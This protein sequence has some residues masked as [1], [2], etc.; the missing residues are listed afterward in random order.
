MHTIV[1]KDFKDNKHYI[2]DNTY[3]EQVSRVNG[4]RYT[5][6]KIVNS[7]NN[8]EAM[9]NIDKRWFVDIY[10]NNKFER[11]I[12]QN[13]YEKFE[14]DVLV[15][16][17]DTLQVDYDNLKHEVV[18][19][20]YNGS[21]TMEEWF[22]YTFQGSSYNLYIRADFQ[23][24]RTLES[25]GY[26]TRLN[27]LFRLCDTYNVEFYIEGKNV[28]I[29]DKLGDYKDDYVEYGLN[30]K[31][32]SRNRVMEGFGTRIKMFGQPIEDEDGKQIGQHE[33]EYTHPLSAEYGIIDLPPISDE[34]FN[35]K[36]AMLERC[37]EEIESSW[38]LS[39]SVELD[40]ITFKSDDVE[41]Y[42]GDYIRI[43]DPRLNFDSIIRVVE[44]RIVY[45]FVGDVISHELI[46]GDYDEDYAQHLKD[47]NQIKELYYTTQSSKDT[48]YWTQSQLEALSKLTDEQIKELSSLTKEQLEELGTLTDE[49]IKE[50]SQLTD[51]QI[52]DLSK[53]TDKEIKEM[54]E[55]A[56]SE[57]DKTNS[58]ID[59]VQEQAGRAGN[60]YRQATEPK[61]TPDIPLKHGDIWYR[62]LWGGSENRTQVIMYQFELEGNVGRWRR[63]ED[64]EMG[65][66]DKLDRG[67]I[68][69][70]VINLINLNA[71]EITSGFISSERISSSS[72]S[73]DKLDVKT[74]SAISANLGRVTAGTLDAVSITGSTIA[75][76]W[77]K[78]DS[79]YVSVDNYTNGNRYTF[80][81][82]TKFGFFSVTEARNR[83]DNEIEEIFCFSISRD[84]IMAEVYKSD[85][86]KTTGRGLGVPGDAGMI[87]LAFGKHISYYGK[88]KYYE[89]SLNPNKQPRNVL[90]P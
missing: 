11:F 7:L 6:F 12:V 28:F 60:I 48:V 31:N 37:K 50:L 72:I 53:K 15:L 49:Q 3:Y 56:T 90:I 82:L 23:K 58:K 40:D 54:T 44:T 2:L 63:V 87:D 33:V 75:G 51:E 8:V 86:D 83:F 57:F 78:P 55:W 26:D 68:N 85:E 45:D 16:E 25:F 89:H 14:D 9:A 67:T 5:V 65:N 24:A 43:F 64:V 47:I 1:V 32:V 46:V 17:I 34:R 35:D 80:T 81:S 66:A 36:N 22:K 39:M 88:P 84:G 18:N 73:A 4:D 42:E 27:L 13:I 30:L 38:N 71:N 74:L 10:K 21:K 70:K 76:G 52:K 69:A 41:I 59:K 61:G 77:L 20:I 79:T 29:V 19:S 62:T